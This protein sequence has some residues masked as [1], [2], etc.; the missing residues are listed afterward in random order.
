MAKGRQ[1]QTK[2]GK[3]PHSVHPFCKKW[4]KRETADKKSLDAFISKCIEIVNTR[5]KHFET[6]YK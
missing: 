3:Q 2:G 5:I 1:D 4:C 6:H